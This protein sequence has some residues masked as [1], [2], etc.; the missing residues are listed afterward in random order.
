MLPEMLSRQKSMMFDGMAQ[1]VPP[2]HE[3]A[4]R[5]A[6]YTAAAVLF[7]A[8]ACVAAFYVYHVLEI[9]IKP[10][11]W[12]LLIGSFLFPFKYS[13][14]SALE[15]WITEQEESGRP[16]I[17]AS[18]LLPISVFDNVAETIG[19]FVKARWKVL[20]TIGS[21]FVVFY[22]LHLIQ[23]LHIFQPLLIWAWNVVLFIWTSTSV[24]VEFFA[25][26]RIFLVTVF[27]AYFITAI[28][29]EP[30]SSVWLSYFAVPA[31][32]SLVICIVSAAGTMQV[33]L[34]IGVAVLI[35]A[36]VVAALKQRFLRADVQLVWLEGRNSLTA[37]FRASAT[38]EILEAKDIAEKCADMPDGVFR[39]TEEQ[40]DLPQS[41]EDQAHHQKPTRAR[42]VEAKKKQAK[43]SSMYFNFLFFG[44]AIIAAWIHAWIVAFILLP[45]LYWSLKQVIY[46]DIVTNFL[47][48]FCLKWF[49]GDLLSL[50]ARIYQ[51]YEGRQNV[52][53]PPSVNAAFD[54]IFM[55]D[56]KVR[57]IILEF[58]P[59]LTSIIIILA[60]I[61]S[62][63]SLSLFFIVKIQ[64]ESFLLVQMTADVMNETV[65]NHPEYQ[66]WFPDNE[67]MLKSVDT[68]VDKVYWQGRDWIKD[69]LLENLGT[70][71]NATLIENQA[72]KLWDHAYNL[73]FNK[74]VIK[75]KKSWRSK[76]VEIGEVGDN[77]VGLFDGLFDLLDMSEVAALLKE[78]M[79]ALRS[80]MESV[81]SIIQMNVS[82]LLS[83]FSTVFAA[84]L[85]G[86]SAVLN[87]VVS[88]VVFFTALFYLLA[89]SDEQYM[90]IQLIGY[91]GHSET[92]VSSKPSPIMTS[93]QDAISGVFGASLKMASFYGLYTWLN[94]TAMG[95]TLVY[96]P[97]LLAAVF[98]VVP[99]F[100][101]YW[102]CFPA[103][104][105]LWIL[106]G[107]LFRALGLL[108]FQFL[109]T[110][111]VDAAIYREMADSGSGHPYVTG[112]SVI[113]GL[114]YFG[115]EGAI[116][117]PILLCI[118]LVVV[119]AYFRIINFPD[120]DKEGQN[121]SSTIRR[122]SSDSTYDRT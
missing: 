111:L 113:G 112:L 72:L 105:E 28:L 25:Q 47:N 114:Y 40:R 64:Q 108:V 23:W 101:T 35:T 80:V 58:L 5:Q 85:T 54:A 79:T 52:L 70:E 62:S 37:L 50:K 69:Q 27:G 11:M 60:L 76:S 61:L 88:T 36:G 16:L 18:A 81:F 74:S 102:S 20:A 48:S 94:H 96:V 84:I 117:G 68:V 116:V 77:G 78:N 115:L 100:A 45:L 91:A 93:I 19:S 121:P 22:L 4:L 98:S 122:S 44:V 120:D 34:G 9:F 31:W 6:F 95:S 55:I 26:Y 99:I 59:T 7:M 87:F 119:N 42:K 33:P 106:Q 97:S 8:A 49:G 21:G 110:M 30:E 51:H 109:P 53:F 118:L 10:L 75:E 46:L 17:I 66:S 38:A 39:S 104:L 90:P 1:L 32:I 73:W 82:L 107:S 24:F 63:V 43:E 56:K 65:S 14:N 15:T 83:S 12:A 92:T 13:L 3:K 41:K 29:L 86:G 103:V 57:S 67:M 71:M 89:G 2:G